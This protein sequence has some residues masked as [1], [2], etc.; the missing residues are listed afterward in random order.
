MEE[1]WGS[2]TPVDLSA[3][4][5]SFRVYI[6]RFGVTQFLGNSKN[7]SYGFI[8]VLFVVS[9]SGISVHNLKAYLH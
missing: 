7:W 8:M 2:A 9:K 5:T 3:D 4:R 1:Q 6:K